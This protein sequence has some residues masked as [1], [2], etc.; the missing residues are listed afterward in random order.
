MRIQKIEFENFRNFRDHGVIEC[1]TD[2]KVTIIYGKNG[3]GKTT[4]HQ[5]FQWVFYGETH[6]NKTA[7]DHLYNLGFER[8]QLFGEVFEVKAS[9]DFEHN[10]KK[11]SI[12]RKKIYR[13]NQENSKE[14]S[15]EFKL[16]KLNENGDWRSVEHPKNAIQRL[17]PSGLSEYFFFDGESMIADLRVKEKDSAK[18]LRKALYSMFD[19]DIIET[20]LDHIGR[21]DLKTSVLGKLY[22]SKG[23]F[24]GGEI[25]RYQTNIKNAQTE[26]D[27]CKN[28]VSNCK[29]KKEQD[30]KE[31]TKISEK[32][33]NIQSKE[34]YE[35]KRNSYIKQREVF[36]ANMKLNKERFGEVI[37]EMFPMLLISKA[38]MDAE[39]KI[40]LKIK[41]NHLPEGIEKRLINYLLKPT[42]TK[43]IC[44]NSLGDTERNQIK[45]YL[46]MMPPKSYKNLF[47]NFIKEAK[48]FGK[49]YNGEKVEMQI[50]QFV[51]NDDAALDCD[52]KIRELD[53]EEKNSPNIEELVI[54]RQQKEKEVENLDK[55]INSNTSKIKD[56]KR[57]LKK[58]MEKFDDLTQKEK[59]T[60]NI[61]QKINI[62]E[63]VREYFE[64]ILK[65][66]SIQYSQQLEKNIQELVDKMLTSKR[67]VNVTKNFSVRVTDSYNDESK[68]EGQFAVISFA[69]IGGILKMLQKAD[70]LSN[71][72]YPLVLDGPFSKLDSD[73]RQNVIN[74][75]PKFAP[76][77]ITF[78]KD[79]LQ[80][81]FDSSNVGRIWTIESNE[82]KNLATVKEGYLWS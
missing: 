4:L 5:L 62:M 52:K 64:N 8:E 39:K 49:E 57:Y 22:L 81:V 25:S 42:T 37:M 43:C 29:E 18:R 9:I 70:G 68:S 63:N 38:I 21:T 24:A 74:E 72:E 32:I 61:L 73:Q 35:K 71:K 15:E 69:Y 16:M 26:I 36:L 60:K 75:L 45:T 41:E 34:E 54:T 14:I 3:D 28:E 66:A 7:T 67:S 27:K 80:D 78:S 82:E 20:A 2:G 48:R 44:G 76:Q 65:D 50:K 56:L 1:S 12:I 30:K 40:D 13:K 51:D 59:T 77:V 53:Q 79:D 47:D 10:D 46:D 17:L 23:T 11:Y 6:F 33:G 55:K 58:S 31:I 19:L